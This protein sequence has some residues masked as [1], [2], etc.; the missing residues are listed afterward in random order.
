MSFNSSWSWNLCAILLATNI[1]FKLPH[2]LFGNLCISPKLEFI[3]VFVCHMT[4]YYTTCTMLLI[5]HAPCWSSCHVHLQWNLDT[6]VLQ[7][8]GASYMSMMQSFSIK[9]LIPTTFNLFVT[10]SSLNLENIRNVV[11]MGPHDIN[12]WPRRCVWL[13]PAWVVSLK[14]TTHSKI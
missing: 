13:D 11:G 5:L 8:I 9:H 7:V 4:T 10:S 12:K 14:T 3:D 6:L 1:L 2:A